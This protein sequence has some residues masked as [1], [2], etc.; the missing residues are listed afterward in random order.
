MAHPYWPLFDLRI[1]TPLI[2][3]RPPTDDDLVE[4][5]A[6]AG[7]GVHAAD[8]MPFLVPWSRRPS[9]ELERSVLQWNWRTRAEWT[10]AGWHLSLVVVRDGRIEGM[11][12]LRSEG[13]ARVR[14]VNT[15]SWLGQEFQGR[16]TGKEMRSAVLHFAFA[17][18]G[19]VA[20]YSGA[21]D[22]NAASIGVSRAVGYEDN[23]D[24]IRD[25]GGKGVGRELLFKMERVAWDARRRD[26][27]VIEGL[28]PCLALFGLGD[29]EP[30][31]ADRAG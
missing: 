19:A 21:F 6:V 29:D 4:L 24:V 20:A 17:G 7:R 12:G 16:G 11:Q 2:E 18:L 3:L 23:G 27:I 30:G 15:G 22:D 5:A 31:G 9:P 8:F 25:R 14:T 10:A 28:E 26:D 1:R 13:F